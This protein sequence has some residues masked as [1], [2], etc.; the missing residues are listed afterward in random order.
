MS[1][2]VQTSSI[3][4]EAHYTNQS[5]VT[6]NKGL[7]VSAPNTMPK[8]HLYDDNDANNRLNVLNNDIYQKTNEEKRKNKSKPIKAIAIIS[9]CILGAL[10]IKH[11]IKILKKS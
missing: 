8:M 11:L 7:I 10:G 4:L 2:E 1:K 5:K 9:T 3:T 6:P